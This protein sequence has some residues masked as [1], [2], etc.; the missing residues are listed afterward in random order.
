MR[1]INGVLDIR[2]ENLN[3]EII[4]KIASILI[5]IINIKIAKTKAS[6]LFFNSNIY[7]HNN[8]SFNS[9]NT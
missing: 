1:F 2:V 6:F 4:I 7:Q 3:C 9:Y 8:P 5:T